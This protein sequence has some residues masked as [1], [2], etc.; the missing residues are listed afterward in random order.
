[1]CIRDSP[2]RVLVT[3]RRVSP[4]WLGHTPKPSSADPGTA[5]TCGESW[6]SGDRRSDPRRS[7]SPSWFGNSGETKERADA[8]W[9]C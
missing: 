8:G 3:S 4:I 7:G 5:L 2:R 6:A 1:M 9:K